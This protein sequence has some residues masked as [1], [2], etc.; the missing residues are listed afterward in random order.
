MSTNLGLVLHHA[1]AN[2]SLYNFF[3]SPAAD[4][5]AHFWVAL[6]GTIEQYV[7]TSTVAWHARDLNIN[8]I[9][10]E[11][12]G[13]VNPP[14]AQPMSMEMVNSLAVLYAEGNRIH[15]WPNTLCESKGAKGFAYHR[16]PG[17]QNGPGGAYPTGC[18]CDTRKDSRQYILDLAFHTP[19][20]T[21]DDMQVIVTNPNNNGQAVLD[22]ANGTYYGFSS[23]DILQFWKDNGVPTAKKQPSREQWAKFKQAGTI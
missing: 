7:D 9:G 23:P 6:D 3:N 15:G 11:T 16:L 20:P 17:S 18:P 1:V 21:G 19:T 22:M 2:G 10:V 8:Y 12:E 5:S 4:V 13:C 14:H